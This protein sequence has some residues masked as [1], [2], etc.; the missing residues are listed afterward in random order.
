M[1]IRFFVLCLKDKIILYYIY[2]KK[3]KKRKFNFYFSTK[4]EK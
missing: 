1:L 2:E 4:K 3:E